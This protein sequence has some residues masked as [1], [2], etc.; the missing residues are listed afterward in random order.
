LTTH[1]GQLIFI[2]GT[3]AVAL[4]NANT[5][6]GMFT[7]QVII[8]GGQRGLVLVLFDRPGNSIQNR[9]YGRRQKHQKTKVENN[10]A[11]RP[12]SRRP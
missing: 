9:I 11:E 3:S 6:V 2:Q 10:N 5:H 4:I 8:K 12:L 7:P 1:K